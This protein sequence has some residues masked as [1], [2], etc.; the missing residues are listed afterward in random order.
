MHLPALNIPDLFFPLWCGLFDC[1]ATDSRDLWDWAVLKRPAV[2]KA[3]GKMVANATPYIPGSFDRPP[4]NPVDIK[5]GNFCFIST[6]SDLLCSMVS[7]RTNTGE[8]TANLC[9][10]EITPT[11]LHEADQ[12]I[13][14]FSD[15]FETIYCQRREDRLHFVRPSIHTPSHVASETA[16][17]VG[18]GII[19]SQS[20][21]AS[22]LTL[23]VNGVEASAFRRYLASMGQIMDENW[24]P[25]ITRW[26]RES[27]K[28]LDKLR[29]AR[30]IKV[31]CEG[32]SRFS[33]V[34]FYC[35]FMVGLEH[36]PLAI[37]SFYGEHHEELYQASSK[38]YVMMQHRGNSDVHVID[39]ESIQYYLMEKPGLRLMEMG[40][41]QET[42]FPED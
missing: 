7:F 39:I 14:E 8:I 29:S 33:E 26:S 15:E 3:H 42:I 6:D 5:P 4:R 32:K 25:H 21:G 28:P 36:K 30:N 1:D 37:V 35:L 41:G 16:H 17:R 40:V 38:T 18:P 9:M 11:E 34:H 31:T 19:Y 22:T 23:S 12:N 20:V 13:M 24:V 10:E 2:W 27:L